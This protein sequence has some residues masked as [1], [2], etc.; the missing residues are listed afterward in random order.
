[1]GGPNDK[2]NQDQG[3][4]GSD[5]GFENTSPSRAGPVD[6]GF[7]GSGPTVNPNLGKKG[8]TL[9]GPGPRGDGLQFAGY[10][11]S[12]FDPSRKN[13]FQQGF[14]LV[15]RAVTNPFTRNIGL[16][17]LGP[18]GY[19]K[20]A[21]QIRTGLMAKGLLD[22]LGPMTDATIEDEL[23]AI[24]TGTD[25]TGQTTALYKDGGLVTLFTEKR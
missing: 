14:D 4:Q 6:M 2:S 18:L 1:M 22:S 21:N 16:A 8:P 20:L 12:T 13:I 11:P 25:V 3:A 24:T 23:E 10:T 15:K 9:V 17:A 19:G 7:I 5:A